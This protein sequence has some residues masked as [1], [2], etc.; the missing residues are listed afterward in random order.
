MCGVLC[1]C[2]GDRPTKAPLKEAMGGEKREIEMGWGGGG[3]GRLMGAARYHL[4]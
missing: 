1:D 3:M 4:L 2:S